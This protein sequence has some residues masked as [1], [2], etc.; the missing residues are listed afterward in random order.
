MGVSWNSVK[1]HQTYD[2]F[3]KHKFILDCLNT[4]CPN[5]LELIIFSYILSYIV[6]STHLVPIVSR[7]KQNLNIDLLHCFPLTLFQKSTWFLNNLYC[8]VFF[9]RWQKNQF[10]LYLKHIIN[11]YF[12]QKNNVLQLFE[13]LFT[14]IARWTC[15]SSIHMA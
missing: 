6:N 15:Y 8:T 14:A 5:F 2:T 13:N 3:F 4:E 1:Q 10:C 7:G 12:R 11:I 9:L